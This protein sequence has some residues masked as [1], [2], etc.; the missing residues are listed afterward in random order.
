MPPKRKAAT[1]HTTSTKVPETNKRQRSHGSASSTIMETSRSSRSRKTLDTARR[2][3]ERGSRNIRDEKEAIGPDGLTKLCEDVGI[4]LE[5]IEILVLAW[6][7]QADKMGYFTKAEWLHGMKSIQADSTNKLIQKLSSLR[8]VVDDD[9]Q[10]K[11]LYDFAFKFAKETDQKCVPIDTA[12]GM[13]KIVLKPE[14][15][16]HINPFLE[17]LDDQQPVKVI[18]RDQWSTFLDFVK[19]VDLDLNG[20]DATSAWP[21]LIDDYVEW[22]QEKNKS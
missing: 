2:L 3:A 14:K 9:D 7:L 6:K 22:K 1:T 13:W 15:Y 18:N 10:F 17:F 11:E 8:A 5:G 19:T 4:S 12:K 16:P 21:T 20:Y